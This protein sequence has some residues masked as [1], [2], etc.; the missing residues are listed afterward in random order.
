MSN[1]TEVTYNLPLIDALNAAREKSQVSYEVV[2]ELIGCK[3][4]ITYKYL[5]K[6]RTLVRG[7]T[8]RRAT[9]TARLL[10][11]MVRNKAL[12]LDDSYLDAALVNF[13]NQDDDGEL[14]RVTKITLGV[15]YDYL[16]K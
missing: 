11:E 14:S 2:S 4:S 10:E 3:K 1:D 12:P 16:D 13:D 5:K 15:I 7:D 9:A 8:E 6:R